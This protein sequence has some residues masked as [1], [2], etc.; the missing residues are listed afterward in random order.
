MPAPTVAPP[1]K[2]RELPAN[3][4][5]L[6]RRAMTGG[7]IGALKKA[8]AEPPTELGPPPAASSPPVRLP[9]QIAPG[10]VAAPAAAPLPPAAPLP[11]AT[12][13][14]R[15]AWR[16]LDPAPVEPPDPPAPDPLDALLLAAQDALAAREEPAALRAALLRVREALP[17]A[18][19]L[20]A[21]LP[22]DDDGPPVR[23][24]PAR[25]RWALALGGMPS[26]VEVGRLATALE[27]DLATARAAVLAGGTRI[28]LRA[29]ERADLERRGTA[30][31]ALGVRFCVVERADLLAFGAAHALVAA[32]AADVWR[33]S[34]QARWGES[35]PDPS[36][37]PRGAACT[38]ADVWLV[39]PGEVEE[40][41]LRPA[42]AESRWQRSHYAAANGAGGEARIA[43]LDLHTEAGVFRVVEGAIDLRLLVGADAAAQ[44]RSIKAFTEAVAA[45]WPNAEVQSR[46]TCPAQPRPGDDRRSDGWGTWEEHSRVCRALVLAVQSRT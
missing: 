14:A 15:A 10:P 23:L 9:P 1:P 27:V 19:A 17:G 4:D 7:G 3:L 46:R 28:V 21:S 35:R 8:L 41:R 18:D 5:D 38:P 12:E 22:A 6:V 16:E 26:G 11:V 39:V 44:R 37:L 32:D 2:T 45:R 29:P 33:V 34:E 31:A 25:H 40:K 43:V 36:Q 24:P 30:V 13:P 42:A 20:V